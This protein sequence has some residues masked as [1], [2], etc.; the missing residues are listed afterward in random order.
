MVVG[1]DTTEVINFGSRV[2]GRFNINVNTTTT[3]MTMAQW[4]FLLLLPALDEINGDNY[5][6]LLLFVVGGAGAALL[7]APDCTAGI[8]IPKTG[9]IP[10]GNLCGLPS[11]ARLEHAIRALLFSAVMQKGNVASSTPPFFITL[12]SPQSSPRPGL[13]NAL[14][15]PGTWTD[16]SPQGGISAPPASGPPYPDGDGARFADL[17]DSCAVRRCRVGG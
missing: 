15:A 3:T 16:H 14:C 17:P 7:I 2:V 5:L 9:S 13:R 10:P 1:V 4:L 11:F 8:E 12:T 6:L